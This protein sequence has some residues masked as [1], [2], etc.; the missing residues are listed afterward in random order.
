MYMYNCLS[1]FSRFIEMSL[2]KLVNL[3]FDMTMLELLLWVHCYK[4]RNGLNLVMLV[5]P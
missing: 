3:T 2:S 5:A 4:H 1:W